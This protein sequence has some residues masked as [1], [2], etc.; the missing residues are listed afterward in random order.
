MPPM[1]QAFMSAFTQSDHVFLGL[2]SA[3]EHGTSILVTDLIQDED[4]TMCPYN[5]RRLERRAAVTSCITSLAHN[6]WMEI[7]SCGLTPQI[8]RIMICHFGVA[9]ASLEQSGPKFQRL[10]RNDRSMIRWISGVKPHDVISI[11]L[12]CA[13]LWIQEVTAALRS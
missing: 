4:R 13:G 11:D 2:P 9:V 1:L 7:S 8:H 3:F 12:L 6:K 10:R 5:L